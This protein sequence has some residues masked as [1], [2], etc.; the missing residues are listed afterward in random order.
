MK[1]HIVM[2]SGGIGSYFTAKRVVAAHGKENTILVFADT[3]IE[4][5]D[6]YRFLRE[7]TQ[8][9]GAELLTLSDGRDPWGVFHDERFLG[10]SRIDPC[11]K[12]LKRSLIRDWLEQNRSPK[13]SVIYLGI[14]WTE[15][16]RLDAAQKYWGDWVVEAP[17][18]DAPYLHKTEMLDALKEE[19]IEVPRLYKMGFPH[20]NCGG[21]CVKS[22]ESQ[23]HLLLKTMPERYKEHEEKEQKLREYLGKDVAILRDRKTKEPMTMRAF[24]ERVESGE[25]AAKH[26]WGGCGCFSPTDPRTLPVSALPLNIAQIETLEKQGINELWEVARYMENQPISTIKGIGPKTQK[27]VRREITRL[28]PS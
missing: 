20:N 19:G 14:D 17:M 7:T 12:V 10:N 27:A 3:L 5:E 15:S 11:S 24:R 2:Y 26:D 28:L 22:G 6:L 16:H 8:S 21:F 25:E 23:F 4:D 13:D 1:K 9:L 18:C